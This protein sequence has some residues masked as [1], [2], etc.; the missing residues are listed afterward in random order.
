MKK[1]RWKG[2]VRLIHLWLGLTSGTVVF[3]IAITGCIYAFQEEIQNA[4]QPYRFVEKKNAPYVMPSEL[5]RV[6]EQNLPGKHI[7][8]IL[9]RDPSRA[10]E[11]I[12][13]SFDPE[14]FYVLYF[15][16]YSGELLKIKNMNNDFFHFILDG[17]FYLWLPPLIGQPLVASFTLIFLFMIVTGLVLWWPTNK[18]A[19]SQR[20]KLR[21][22]PSPKRR[23][24]DLHTVLGFYASSIALL[25]VITGLVWGF[26]WFAKSIYKTVG[27]EKELVYAIPPSLS[28]VDEVNDSLDKLWVRLSKEFNEAK[29]I[30]I[31]LPDT[32]HGYAVNINPEAGTYW[33]TDFRYYDP[34]SLKELPVSHIYGKSAEA[35]LADKTMRMNY[36][37]HTG[38]ILGITG[39]FI[40]FCASL[41]VASL[42]VTGFLIWLWR[43]KRKKSKD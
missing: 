6:V 20:F 35:T 38:A 2:I 23:N 37:I 7:H 3:I 26:E 22:N 17:H 27:G 16:P 40:A 24:H 12:I 30:E 4:T 32:V 21:R 8:S 36:D 39:K 25:F 10:S 11:A 9:Y 28:K 29:S 1:F 31:H 34:N 33:K 5:K 43:S 19:I 18:N 41:I 14:Y 13:Y 15:N 42:P